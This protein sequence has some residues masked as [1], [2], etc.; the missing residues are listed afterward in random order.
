MSATQHYDIH[1]CLISAQAA[2]NLLPV[3]EPSF[4]PKQA[5]FLVSQ[6]MKKQANYLAKVYQQLGIKVEQKMLTDEYSF[7]KMEQEML[8]LVSQYENDNIAANIT[9]GMKLMSIALQNAFILV[10]K[11]LF[12]VDTDKQ[13]RIIFLSKN[14]QNQWV[15][16]MPLKVNSTIEQYLTAYG[17]HILQQEKPDDYQGWCDEMERLFIKKYEDYEKILPSLNFVASSAKKPKWQYKLDQDNKNNKPLIDLLDHFDYLDM[18][19]YNG[20]TI[21]FEDQE[22]QTFFNGG[23]LESYCYLQLKDIKKIS[24]ISCNLKVGNPNYRIDKSEYSD[25]NKGNQNEFDIVFMA[26]NKLHII[27]CKTQLMQKGGDIKA[28]DILYKLETLKDY[29]GLMTK[30][31]LVSYFEVSDAVL[32]RARELKIEIIQGEELKQLKAKIENWIGKK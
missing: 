17:N 1:V 9:G 14:E 16:D 10:N 22:T 31:C 30:K 29:G 24:D 20:E 27:E 6:S 23:W 11:P 4:R 21:D 19:N 3:L 7:P 25:E 26:E 12:Y 8:D 5:I 28:D 2:P 15:E 18:L 13:N 32:N